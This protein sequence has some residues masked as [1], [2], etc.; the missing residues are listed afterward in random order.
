[1]S[2]KIDLV[3]PSYQEWSLPFNAERSVNLFPI[4]DKRGKDVAALYGTPGKLLFG[5]AGLGQCRGAF[6]ASNGRGFIVSAA[7]LYEIDSAGIATS[8]GTLLTSSG[9]IS[10]AE[11]GFQLGICDGS[12]VYIFT[13]A[14]NIFALVTSPN[15]PIAGTITFIDGYFVVNKIGTGSF[16]ISA[17]YDGTTW[18]ALD[19][20]TAESSPDPLNRVFNALGQLWLLG[21]LTTQIYTNTGNAA[22]PFQP[23]AGAKLDMGIL[24]PQT[25]VTIESSIIFLAQDEFG[26]GTVVQTTS[27]VPNKISTT[28]IDLLINQAND[29]E[30]IVA[31]VYQQQGH[32]FYVLTGGG[33][34]TSLVYDFTTQ[35]W[36]ERAYLNSMGEYETDRGYCA[37]FI[38]DKQLLGD[39]E[40]GNIYEMNMNVYSDNE[41]PILRER[42][43]THLFDDN[44]RIRYNK[45]NIGFE[46]GIGLQSGQGQNPLVALQLSKDG[47]KTWSTSFTTAIGRVGAYQTQVTFRR[48]GISQQM[49]FRIKISDPVKIAIIGSY[50][51]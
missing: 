49:T 3:G 44:Q 13:Y 37:M 36:H 15:I 24:A 11:N 30:N 21:T 14:T 12:K 50:L 23:I 4:M 22:F 31:Y 9:N 34:E 42:I 47:A 32:V 1:M 46:T 16:Y 35:L 20:A 26:N 45:L 8:R 43:Y 41:E 29:K 48:L 28:P 5:V 25:A 10:I 19:F 33:L 51:N 7:T 27:T 2:I 18:A 38:F 6:A 39:K 17:L 40:N